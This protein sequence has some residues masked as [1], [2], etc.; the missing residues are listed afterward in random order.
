MS[1]KDY[2]DAIEQNLKKHLGTGYAYKKNSVEMY[3][4]LKRYGSQA[5]AVRNAKALVANFKG[6]E[7]FANHNACTMVWQLIEE[8]DKLK[9]GAPFAN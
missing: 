9:E 2:Q 3:Q 4:L 5:D 8:V 1:R 7:N 6:D